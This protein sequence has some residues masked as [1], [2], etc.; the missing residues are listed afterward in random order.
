MISQV[1]SMVLTSI[2]S[3]C[4]VLRMLHPCWKVQRSR[5]STHM[6]H[7][8]FALGSARTPPMQYIC[9]R[10]QMSRWSDDQTRIATSGSALQALIKKDRMLYLCT[11]FKYCFVSTDSILL[12][13]VYN[14]LKQAHYVFCIYNNTLG[15]H[16][17]HRHRNS[18]SLL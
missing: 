8:R 5:R 6:K 14:H 2:L 11:V 16:Q 7:D 9:S 4:A 15:L 12:Y 3:F 17:V 18:V 13:G 10:C 1:V